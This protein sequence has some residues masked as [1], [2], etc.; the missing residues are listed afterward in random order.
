[1]KNKNDSLPPII[2]PG[3]DGEDIY[4][5]QEEWNSWPG[6][7]SQKR[8]MAFAKYSARNIRYSTAN[9]R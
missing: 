8:D 4:V 6:S 7:D 2:I 5:S 9:K 1:M 3:V